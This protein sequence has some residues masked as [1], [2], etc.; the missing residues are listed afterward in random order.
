MAKE[1][2]EGSKLIIGKIYLILEKALLEDQNNHSQ[3]SIRNTF[4]SK[5]S[6]NKTWLIQ[7]KRIF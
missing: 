2:M 1:I 4:H 6:N 3:I 7:G 5:E